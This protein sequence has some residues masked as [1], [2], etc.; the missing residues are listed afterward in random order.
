METLVL[1][2]PLRHFPSPSTACRKW[3]AITSHATILL[4]ISSYGGGLVATCARVTNVEYS[5]AVSR[6]LCST[7]P[8]CIMLMNMTVLP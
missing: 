1:G 3:S 6:R 2:R 4:R 5:G 8:R 7:R